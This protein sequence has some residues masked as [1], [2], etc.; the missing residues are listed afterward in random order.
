MV[1]Q[2]RPP[3]AFVC[4]NSE[5]LVTVVVTV[6]AVP[7]D[8]FGGGGVMTMVGRG[9]LNTLRSLL[10]GSC[11]HRPPDHLALVAAQ[12]HFFER[13]PEDLVEDGVEDGIDHR[14]R[15][16]QPGHEVKHPLAEL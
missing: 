4:H 8:F 14:G 7:V 9:T 15:V 16:A 13:L 2:T 6:V 1:L 11:G 3:Y 10:P 5:V 12:Q